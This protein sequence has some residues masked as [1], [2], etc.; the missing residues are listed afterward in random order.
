M[1]DIAVR[2]TVQ[3]RVEGLLHAADACTMPT[4]G[5]TGLR[6]FQ[7]QVIHPQR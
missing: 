1:D 5:E 2:V 6:A 4:F 7:W 3:V